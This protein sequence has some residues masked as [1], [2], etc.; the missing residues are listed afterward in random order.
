ML[1][2]FL[3]DWAV[4]LHQPTFF[5][6]QQH[7][8]DQMV[9]M[10]PIHF[11]NSKWPPLWLNGLNWFIVIFLPLPHLHFLLSSLLHSATMLYHWRYTI[12]CI[13]LS[14]VWWLLF[15]TCM[16]RNG[17]M[18]DQYYTIFFKQKNTHDFLQLQVKEGSRMSRPSP[19]FGERLLD[20]KKLLE[21]KSLDEF[22][23]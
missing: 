7:I 6:Q 9:H 20:S 22:V 18:E 14:I 3:V 11:T 10:Y 16:F 13:V 2:Q 1:S 23:I 21:S 15:V 8:V 17:P 5:L 19:K 4:S 12:V